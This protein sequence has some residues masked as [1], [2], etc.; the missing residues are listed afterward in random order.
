MFNLNNKILDTIEWHLIVYC[1][2]SSLCILKRTIN[3]K[4]VKSL[5]GLSGVVREHQTKKIGCYF[6]IIV[7]ED[8]NIW[9]VGDLKQDYK[10]S[11]VLDGAD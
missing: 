1:S 2:M 4:N 8:L 7:S 11:K 6:V 10:T 9:I 5:L 3:V